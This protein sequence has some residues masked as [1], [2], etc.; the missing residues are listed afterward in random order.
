MNKKQHC[1]CCCLLVAAGYKD[2]DDK[3]AAIASFIV[4]LDTS[5]GSVGGNS[6]ENTGSGGAVNRGENIF[7]FLCRISHYLL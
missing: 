1:C 4:S 7:I 6:E 2:D 3:V 5:N